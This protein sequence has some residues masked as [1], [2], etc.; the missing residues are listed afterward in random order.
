V[1]SASPASRGGLRS[2]DVIVE[3]NG[4][5]TE[6]AHDAI[7]AIATRP[8][9][10][11]KLVIVRGGQLVSVGVQPTAVDDTG[12]LTVP[13]S[14]VANTS[15]G[16]HWCDQSGLQTAVCVAGGMF[17]LAGFLAALS[18]DTGVKSQK[19]DK[20]DQDRAARKAREQAMHRNV[21]ILLDARAREEGRNP[22]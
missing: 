6:T 21:E 20:A 4:V 5:R 8:G 3:V 17:V 13:A 9:L 18:D 11:T 16:T 19:P 15:N 2:G 22:N 7:L 12:R 10:S 1:E 14:M